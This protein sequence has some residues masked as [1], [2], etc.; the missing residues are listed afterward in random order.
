MVP[1]RPLKMQI[2]YTLKTLHLIG[3]Y[4]SNNKK[5]AKMQSKLHVCHYTMGHYQ[6]QGKIVT[7]VR[8]QCPLKCSPKF[9]SNT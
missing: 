7:I 9:E 4:S 2:I 8:D 5:M 3:T 1:A 6:T